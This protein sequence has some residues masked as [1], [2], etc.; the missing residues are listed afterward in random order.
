MAGKMVPDKNK[1]G[2]GRGKPQNNVQFRNS[3]FL[4]RLL[5]NKNLLSET[6]LFYKSFVKLTNDSY[7]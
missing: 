4:A 2:Q 5:Q 3:L 1:V 6:I 7:P